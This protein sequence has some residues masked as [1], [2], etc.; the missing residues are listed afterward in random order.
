[1]SGDRH[2]RWNMHNDC[3]QYGMRWQRESV[4]FNRN[5]CS[6]F[7]E[8]AACKNGRSLVN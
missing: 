3:D 7:N 1:M 6:T 2:R 5:G 8:R 4:W